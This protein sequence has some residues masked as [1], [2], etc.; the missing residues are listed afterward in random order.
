MDCRYDVLIVGGGLVG[1]SLACALGETPLQVALVE[2]VPL[3]A[4]SQPSYDERVIALSW[5]S[6]RIFEGLGLWTALAQEAEPIRQVHIS[7]RG[8]FGFAHLHC[9]EQGTEALGYVVP[10]RALGR[11]LYQRI[12]DQGRVSLWCPT[13][14]RDYQADAQ[15][16]VARLDRDGQRVQVGALLLVAADGG[17]SPI[18]ERLGLD[19]W[20]WSYGQRAM[21]A[22]L[23]PERPRTGVAFERFTDTGP[24]ALLPMTEG[25]YSLVWTAREEEAPGL[26]ALSEPEFLARLQVRFGHRLGRLG[27]LGQRVSFPL[28]LVRVKHPV[29]E[30]VALIGNAAH[31]LHPVA[32]QGFNLGL[33]DV[34][35]LAELLLDEGGGDPGRREVLERFATMRRSDQRTM[36]LLTDCL[37]R[38]FTHPYAPLVGFRN[39]G[40]LALDL[41]PGAKTTLARRLMGLSDA[42][43]RLSRGLPLAETY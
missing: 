24:L 38:G 10:A 12:A 29:G 3:R 8:H 31:S 7:D 28:R 4:P 14:L 17:S 15:G 40:L 36:A 37:V 33:R 5:G 42:Q 11:A 9:E 20:H 30:R 2:E 6:R 13:Q 27:R 18:R 19:G 34:A 35:V 22:T 16:V 21:I 26:L 39:A 32:G 41:L 1:A 43:P 23:S 25:R